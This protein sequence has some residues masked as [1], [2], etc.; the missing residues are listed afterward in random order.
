[1]GSIFGGGG[2]GSSTTVQ[3][4]APWAG[5]QPYLKDVMSQAQSLYQSGQGQQYF[6]YSTVAPMTPQTDVGLSLMEDRALRGSPITE[7]AQG[8]ATATLRGD[9]L[10]PTQ[11]PAYQTMMGDIANR[12][13]SQFGLSGRTGGGAHSGAL[14]RGM[15]E[16]GS[17]IYSQERANQ[18]GMLGM[19]PTIEGMDVTDIQRLMGVGGLR[20]EQE[21][22]LLDDQVNRFNFQQNAPWD[23]LSRYSGAVSGLG[24]LGG[25]STT[26]GN[27]NAGAMSNLTSL[28]GLGLLGYSVLGGL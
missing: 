3:S 20:G 25:T 13:N 4:S 18:M 28:G 27:Q 24:S 26:S 7:Q 6:P 2:G 8:L 14:A 22:R 1:M 15:T 11:N 19:A 21:Q 5:S 9:Y 12:V 23:A 16:G 10:D 17:N